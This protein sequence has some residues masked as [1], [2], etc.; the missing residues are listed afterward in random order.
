MTAVK[1]TRFMEFFWKIHPWLYRVSGG[2]ILGSFEGMPVLLLTTTG[3]KSGLPKTS[4]LLY[5]PQ[6]E[7]CIVI[8]SYAGEP[9]HPA[10]FLNLRTN[11]R[12]E[13]QV[14][15]RRFPVVARITEGEERKRL[16]SE[17]IERESSY[18]EYQQRT[19]RQI[20]VVVLQP[21]APFRSA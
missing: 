15:A 16:W 10:W 21:V 14:R 19:T 12:A 4:P 8:G 3:R 1:R 11:P 20:P 5:L 7:S 18:A 6:G 13:V 17:I 9:R 2:R